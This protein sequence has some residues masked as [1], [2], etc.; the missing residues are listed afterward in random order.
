MQTTINY[1]LLLFLLMLFGK[2]GWG[3]SPI[4]SEDTIQ[5]PV[6][7]I[8]QW[9]TR[10]TRPGIDSIMEQYG[11][12]LMNSIDAKKFEDRIIIDLYDIDTF[13][14]TIITYSDLINFFE[15]DSITGVNGT[16]VSLGSRAKAVDINQPI[17]IGNEECQS[18]SNYTFYHPYGNC[19]VLEYPDSNF[20][21]SRCISFCRKVNVAILD[22]GIDSMDLTLKELYNNQK[23]MSFIEDKM[24]IH[25]SN[26]HGSNVASIIEKTI[27]QSG[28][29]DIDIRSYKVLD[30]YGEGEIFIILQALMEAINQG[31]DIVNISLGV[32]M[33]E[34]DGCSSVLS[35]IL[36]L[37]ETE[38][39][40]VVAA[41]GNDSLNIDECYYFPTSST[42]NSLLSVGASHCWDSIAIFSNFGKKSVDILAPGTN[43]LFRNG[44][45]GSGTSF[46]A[47]IITAFSAQ[48]AAKSQTFSAN[49][50][51]SIILGNVNTKTE[52][53]RSTKTGGV[54]DPQKLFR[55]ECWNECPSN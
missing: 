46:S 10:A 8:I 11:G 29:A 42:N 53:Y 23:N 30:G 1:F 43:I 4:A 25:D 18:N 12:K 7:L 14:Y 19:P 6:S 26:G 20:F 37:A 52:W 15:C 9:D 34:E 38:N 28:D 49:G 13:P 31:V 45:C 39:T 24:G 35:N 21:K 27:A 22:S 55:N 47:P 40:L 36:E 32:K 17:G 3:Q 48:V 16:G 44:D 5:T 2:L 33:L 54:S 50:L 51:K 41:A